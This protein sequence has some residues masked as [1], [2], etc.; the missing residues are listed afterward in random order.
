MNHLLK[1]VEVQCKP[2]RPATIM[3]GEQISDET[4]RIG[5]DSESD[6]GSKTGPS[7]RSSPQYSM[8][9]PS[10]RKPDTSLNPKKA[11]IQKKT[12]TL[13]SSY[14]VFVPFFFCYVYVAN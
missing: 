4:K 5:H 6:T 3:S 1:I 10:K 14:H 8:K 11:K 9:T 13:V 7:G 12:S 2:T